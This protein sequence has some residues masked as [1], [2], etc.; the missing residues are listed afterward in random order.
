[1]ITVLDDRCLAPGEG[2]DK[3]LLFD[4]DNAYGKHQHYASFATDKSVARNGFVV[5]HY[6]G[7]VVGFVA[8]AR[9]GAA[10]RQ[11]V[12]ASACCKAAVRVRVLAAPPPSALPHPRFLCLLAFQRRT[13]SKGF[14][15]PTTTF[16]SAISNRR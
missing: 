7:D 4:F 6:A 9:R 3:D 11:R 1:M 12:K 15:T 13:P 16:S 8:D 14:W 5:K 10:W 2:T